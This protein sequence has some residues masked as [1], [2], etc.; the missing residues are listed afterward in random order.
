MSEIP[1]TQS[2]SNLTSF[3]GLIQTLQNYWSEQGCLIMQPLDMEVGAGTF[4]P[5]TFIRAI[6]P[7][8]WL[9]A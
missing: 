5:A 1:A 7:Q 3:Q 2:T 9:A 6:G 4:H 8:P